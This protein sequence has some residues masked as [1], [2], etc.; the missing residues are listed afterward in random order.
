MFLNILNNV[1]L[2]FKKRSKMSNVESDSASAIFGLFSDIQYADIDDRSFGISHHRFYRNSVN[3]MKSAVSEWQENY[4]GRIKFILHL[5]D[6]ID[7][8]A[9][10]SKQQDN[11]L[12]TVLD[13]YDEVN[14]DRVPLYH[15]W[16]NHEMYNF[17]RHRLIDSPF[18]TAK[19][20]GQ[21]HDSNANYYRI[22]VTDNLSLL[23]LD[24]YRFSVI[25]YDSN[26]PECKE[27]YSFLRKYES[28][29]YRECFISSMK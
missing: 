15:A 4:P 14:K 24:F 17:E 8:Q 7:S 19:I 10:I 27:A 26:D 25:G 12:K 11:A 29:V 6:L 22:D 5:G 1:S 21:N 13:A 9:L 3:L 18:H 20:L 23:V 16:G 28:I 2:N